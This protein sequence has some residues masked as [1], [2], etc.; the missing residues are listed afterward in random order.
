MKKKPVK[1]FTRPWAAQK[2]MN[3]F[4]KKILK[5]TKIHLFV[6]FFICA[7]LFLVG[8]RSRSEKLYAEAYEKINQNEFKSAIELLESSADLEKN[9]IKK[10]KA[11]FEAARLLRF[12]RQDYESALKHLRT[13]V[14]SSDDE[15]MRLLAQESICEIYF[16]H[17][18]NYQEA[19][20][21]LLILEPLQPESKKKELLRLKTAQAQHLI[22]NG[23]AALEYIDSVLKI[24]TV[25]KNPFLKLKAQVLQSENKFDEALKIYDQIYV[26]SQNYFKTENLFYAVSAIHEEKKDYKQGV[27]YLEKHNE[28]I[29]DKNYLEL[30]IKKLKEKQINK[31][32]SKGVR[33]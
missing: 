12:E 3:K 1:K 23:Q 28:E 16:D 27:E 11:L 13:V 7:Q 8:C 33:K 18:Q 14:L 5:A 22:G 10:T 21:E 17:L 26:S 19:L 32:F 25:D 4:K 9:N 6:A 24:S 29:A 2:A 15:K 30:R 31:P 20:K